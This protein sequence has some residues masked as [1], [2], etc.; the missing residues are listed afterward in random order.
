MSDQIAKP[1]ASTRG[2]LVPREGLTWRIIFGRQE[3]GLLAIF[4]L[5]CAFLSLATSTFLTSTNISNMLRAFSWIAIAA[6]GQ[7]LVILTAGIDLS[8]GSNMALSGLAAALLLT[9]GMPVPVALMGGLLTGS[10]VGAVNG[11][12]VTRFRLPP[13][14]ATLGTLSIARGITFGA[15]QGWPVRKLPKAFNFIGQHNVPIGSWGVPFPVII[16]L[17]LAVTVSLYLSRTVRGRHIYAVGGDEEASRLSGINPN[18]IKMLVYTSSGLLA[19]TG[20]ILMTA[21]LGVAAPTAA[22]GYEL[23]II[24]ACVIGGVSLFGGEGTILGVLIGAAFMQ[25][26]RT[27]LNLLGVQAY[28][29]PAAIGAVILLAVMFDQWHKGG[30]WRDLKI[31]SG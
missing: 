15:T 25:T 14:I 20:G 22:M 5:W 30:G 26:I 17:I 3:I 31:F 8:V 24:A 9:A 11:A 12:L 2:A 10:I 19:A 18:W 28:W 4:L 29:Q 6:F 21:R 1:A 23:D 16:V 27:G 7:C 13:F